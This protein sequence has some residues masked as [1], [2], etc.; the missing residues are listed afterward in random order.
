MK[1]GIFWIIDESL[2]CVVV[3][4][5]SSGTPLETVE[6]SAKSGNNFNHKLEWKKIN[7]KTTNGK[8]YNYYH[9]G[10]VEI[11]NNKAT[12]YINP[13]ANMNEI[14][15]KIIKSFNLESINL[16]FK[17]DGSVHYQALIDAE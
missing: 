2:V 5:D 17:S 14:Q 1:K 15:E 13:L 4:C 9:R 10:R 8:P 7:K 16:V 6:F 12:V 3:E 11:K